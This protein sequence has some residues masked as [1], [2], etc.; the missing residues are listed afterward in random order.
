M[1]TVLAGG[2]Q[3]VCWTAGLILTSIH[4]ADIG[5]PTRQAVLGGWV[6]FLIIFSSIFLAPSPKGLGAYNLG[7]IHTSVRLSIRMYFRGQRFLRSV[8]IK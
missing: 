4:S 3:A 2:E 5:Q 7:S 1:A 6:F 8:W